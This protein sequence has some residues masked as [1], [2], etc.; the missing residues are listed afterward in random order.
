MRIFVAGATGVIGSRAVA[1]FRRAG[2]DV[3]GIARTPEKA[4][5]LRRAGATPVSV[6]LFDADALRAA[7]AGH[8]AVVNL[9]TK[10]PS[11]AQAARDSAWAENTRIRTEG[12]R[13]LVDAAIAAGAEV[14]VQES[15]AFIYGEHG[16]A[17]IDA[18]TTDVATSPFTEPAEAAEANALRFTANGGRGVAL[19][20]GM[21]QAAESK[22]TELI[23]AAARK[24]VFMDASRPDAYLPAI[25]TDDAARAV[26]AALAAPSG[27]Y[28]VVDDEPLPRRDVARALAHAVGRRRLHWPP[29]RRLAAKKIGP[30]GNSQRVSNERFRAVT[31]WRPAMRSQA[32]SIER[33]AA[34]KGEEPALP[35]VGRVLLWLLAL[36]G[37][38]VGIYAE[39]FPRA[40]YDDF[41]FGRSWVMHDGPFNEHLVRDFG[42]MNLALTAVTLAA[43]YF[44]SL[45]AAR[46]SALG[47]VVFSVPHAVY[48][49]RNLSHYDTPDKIGNVVSLSSGVLLAI[50]ALV[51]L[52][53]TPRRPVINS[54]PVGNSYDGAREP[55]DPTPS[56][57]EHAAA[58]VRNHDFRGDVGA[59][60]GDGIDQ[61]RSG[62]S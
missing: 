36:T 10:I 16:D 17:W 49:F 9:A 57:R 24:G 8:D 59:G 52:A 30:L 50:A 41:P 58:G 40:F 29:G 25:D 18:N 47:W 14:F 37:L 13:N 1:Q 27:V 51:V 53:R 23:F 5:Q 35:L 6:S 11:P 56:L 26:L 7:V 44:G 19:R 60:G 15:I 42:A 31:D 39:F 43:L 32:E 4:A 21:F 62:V 33:M 22:H 61:P 38:A 28:D 48:H 3:T 2:H 55:A 45:A 12:S 34:T 20:F 46:A 54:A